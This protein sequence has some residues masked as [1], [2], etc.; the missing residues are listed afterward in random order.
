MHSD[1][2]WNGWMR[3]NV[4]PKGHSTT[5]SLEFRR[6]QDLIY[7]HTAIVVSDDKV[8]FVKARIAK[9]L[10]R[11]GINTIGEYCDCI[12]SG[13][14]SL[15]DFTSQVTTNHTYFFRESHHFDM[16]TRYLQENGIRNKTIWSAACSS[17]EEPYSV[18][19]TLKEKFSI[20]AG[21]GLRLLASDIDEQILKVAGAGKYPEERLRGVTPM[22]KRMAFEYDESGDEKKYQVRRS[23][24]EMV[25]F[26]K[27]NL[28]ESMPTC[29]RVEVIFC[30]NV[31]IYF[32]R[33]TKIN[34]FNRFSRLQ[35]R[36]DL[37]FLGHSESLNDLCNGYTCIGGTT[38]QKN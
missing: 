38:Y 37:L 14:E 26:S 36:G 33:E 10:R 2:P 16:L 4:A 30:R 34:L 8:D 1:I 18:A 7:K 21:T 31:A 22:Q 35:K 23:I 9:R 20:S 15:A 32:D 12:E 27:I 24:M 11:F 28:I 17:G 29:A 25:D 3:E 5:P 13:E 19:I 6:I